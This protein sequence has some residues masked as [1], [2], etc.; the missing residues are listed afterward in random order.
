M[1]GE[2]RTLSDAD[3]DAI[4]EKLEERVIERFQMNVGKGILA[5]AWKWFLVG[6]VALAVYG[7]AG[8]FK[9]WGA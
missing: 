2:K 5:A 3:I 6:L 1:V 9:K 4:T 8:G 7:A